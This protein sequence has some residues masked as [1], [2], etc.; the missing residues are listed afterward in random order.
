M[1]CRDKS[2]LP[3]LTS[4]SITHKSGQLHEKVSSLY[5]TCINKYTHPQRWSVRTEL[6]SLVV[7]CACV[8]LQRLPALRGS[9]EGRHTPR[10]QK[11]LQREGGSCNNTNT[12]FKPLAIGT[13][14]AGH[15][16][17]IFHLS[18]YVN[19]IEAEYTEYGIYAAPLFHNMGQ[20]PHL[21]LESV[22]LTI[23][24]PRE[25]INISATPSLSFMLE[26]KKLYIYINK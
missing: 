7:S 24:T 21:P 5:S 12:H 15:D 6:P 8:C 17:P 11:K 25:S 23:F 16:A 18:L 13:F 10:D 22:V 1:S 9:A 3:L 26:K 4:A 19:D 14:E 20:I 2:A